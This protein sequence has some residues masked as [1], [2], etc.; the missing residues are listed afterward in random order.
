M[1]GQ[2]QDGATYS[3]G[4]KRQKKKPCI[5]YHISRSVIEIISPFFRVLWYCHVRVTADKD[6]VLAY[7]KV[8]TE[9]LLLITFCILACM[10]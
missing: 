6:I 1:F 3:E 2:M 4:V 8:N 5:Q 10:L 7:L 9:K